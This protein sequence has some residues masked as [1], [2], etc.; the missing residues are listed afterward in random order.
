[1]K[2]L[3]KEVAR[4]EAELRTPDVSKEKD[5]KIQQ[6]NSLESFSLS[7]IMGANERVKF[8]IILLYLDGDG[9]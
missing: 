2:H 5:M 1:M 4:L 9:N 8:L 6:V 7:R 3:Q